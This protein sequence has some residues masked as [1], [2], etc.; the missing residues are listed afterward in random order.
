MDIQAICE[1][2]KATTVAENQ[3]D[4]TNYLEE[5]YIFKYYVYIFF[6]F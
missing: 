5:V 4:T 2:L 1:A 6:F 3:A